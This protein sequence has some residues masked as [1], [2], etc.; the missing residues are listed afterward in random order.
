MNQIKYITGVLAVCATIFAGCNK[1]ENYKEFPSG[2]QTRPGPVSNVRVTPI[3]GGAEITYDLPKSPNLLYVLAEYRINDQM[4]RQTKASYYDNKLIVEGFRDAKP[5]D[6]KLTVV[7]RSETASDPVTVSVTPKEPIYK[8]VR[9]DLTIQPDFGGIYVSTLNPEKK[10]LGVIILAQNQYKEWDVIE[11]LF[12][13]SDSIRIKVRGYP[14][15]EREFRVYVTDKWNNLSDTL[16]VTL[17]PIFEKKIDKTLFKPFPLPTDQRDDYGWIMPYLWDDRIGEPYGFHTPDGS[18]TP[19]HFTFDLGVEAKLSRFKIWPR[20]HST[21]AWSHGNPR[22]FR[23][24]G[25]TAPNPDGSFDDT[26]VLL[27][28]YE[29]IK[30]SGS[31]LGTNTQEDFDAAVAGF[32]YD[33]PSTAG[34][35]RYIRF[36]TLQT[37]SEDFFHLMEMTLW[38]AD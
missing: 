38:G 6:V 12:T 5:Y 13:Q 2:D 29:C 1:S 24:W 3:N 16:A 15:E 37:W 14:S 9:Q 34:K 20:T 7:T 18:N 30:P 8:L 26:W 17:T 27:G 25:S 36:E 31:P 11:Q 22:F 32:D 4:T 23:I 28:E 35:V 33:L 19:Q 21:F 10:S